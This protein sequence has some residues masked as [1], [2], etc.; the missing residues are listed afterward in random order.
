[1]PGKYKVSMSLTSAGETKL[2]AGPVEFNAVV[3]NNTL[4]YLQLTEQPS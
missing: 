1:M 3:L 2:L 4:R